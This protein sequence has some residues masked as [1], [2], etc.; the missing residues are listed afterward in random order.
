MLQYLIF[1]ALAPAA[2]ALSAGIGVYAWQRRTVPAARS[3]AWLAGAI[4]GWLTCN[5]LELVC[6]T[7]AGTLTW[8]KLTYVFIE[9]SALAWLAFALDYTGEKRWLTRQ[10]FGLLLVVPVIITLLA[11]TN[12]LHSLIWRSYTFHRE[13]GV[14]AIRVLTYGPVFWFQV[15]FNYLLVMVGAGLIGRAYLAAPP[16]FHQQA[17]WAIIGAV[18]PLAINLVYITR[19]VPGL[20][21]DYSPLG[22][23]LAGTAFGVAIFRH[24]LLRLMPI[25]RQA[26]MDSMCEGMIVLD[27]GEHIIDLNPAA[28]FIIDHTADDAFGRP[29]DQVWPLWKTLVGADATTPS[30]LREVWVERGA[31]S[32]CFD[33]RIS[34]LADRRGRQTGQLILLRDITRHKEIEEELRRFNLE[35]QARNAELDA[36]AHTAAHDLKRPLSV[37]LGFNQLA[38]RRLAAVPDP[39]PF[40]EECV[41]TIER[42]GGKM[43]DIVNELLMLA[44]VRQAEV[45]PAPIDTAALVA[46]ARENLKTLTAERQ[47]T[48]SQPDAWPRA[49]GHAQWIEQVWTN[50]LSNALKYG[51]NPPRIDLGAEPF[52]DPET[53]QAMIRY[54]VRD[55]GPGLTPDERNRLFT[56][57]ARMHPEQAEGHGL[58]LFLIRRIIEKLGGQVGVETT[59]GEGSLFYFSL[60]AAGA[61]LP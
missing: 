61:G 12:D 28:R 37:I 1:I 15:G 43:A 42:T 36:F 30:S 60:P 31:T 38:A 58:G 50:L 33:V 48:I 20:Y 16:P 51:G 21:K 4:A 6:P 25:A 27:E 13:A 55:N 57:F 41:R 11:L 52:T 22:F 49:M 39:D 46:A 10:R 8:S 9:L 18:T 59:L 35:L 34:S 29:L 23:A 47:A 19:L 2:I 54:W 40:I 17:R 26:V 53:G 24:R 5:T 14:V 44:S 32:Y 45:V 7:E 3:L 56:A